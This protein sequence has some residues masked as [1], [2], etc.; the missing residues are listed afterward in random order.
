MNPYR[1]ALRSI[2]TVPLLA[3]LYFTAEDVGWW[4]IIGLVA[5][6]VGLIGLVALCVHLGAWADD[7][8]EA[9]RQ[10]GHSEFNGP[11]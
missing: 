1:I 10:N 4:P 5:G 2:I 7:W 9:Q 3:L 11:K 6:A 8:D